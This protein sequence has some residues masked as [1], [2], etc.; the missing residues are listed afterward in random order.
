MLL[1]YLRT[2]PVAEED[3]EI[4]MPADED[5]LM[6]LDE[7]RTFHG[8]PSEAPFAAQRLEIAGVIFWSGGPWPR[9]LLAAVWTRIDARRSCVVLWGRVRE[10]G[11]R[12]HRLTLLGGRRRFC[13]GEVGLQL[14]EL[15]LEL[16]GI[17]ARI[18]D[19]VARVIN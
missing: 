4:S 8:A 11:D 9:R 17:S 2:Q 7:D 6:R 10:G 5:A 14:L 15:L 1:H 3:L 18:Y 19:M 13:G 12:R 16:G